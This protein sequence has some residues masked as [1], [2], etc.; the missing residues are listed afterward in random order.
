MLNTHKGH[1][2]VKINSILNN[3]CERRT[4]S[5]GILRNALLTNNELV[6]WSVIAKCGPITISK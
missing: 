5:E 3:C 2:F 6:P 1:K 4:L